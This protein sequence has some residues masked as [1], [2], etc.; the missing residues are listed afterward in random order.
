MDNALASVKGTAFGLGDAAT[1]AASAVAAGIQPG[2]DLTKYLKDVGDAAAIAGTNFEDMGSIFNKIQTSNKA[3]TD[4]L[5]Q[6]SDRGLPIFQWLQKEYGVTGEALSKMVQDGDVDSAHF[7]KAIEDN[8]SGAALKMGQSFSGSVD[9]AEAALGRLGAALLKPLFTNAAGGLGSI[10]DGLDSMTKWVNDHQAE[11]IG[12][13]TNVGVAAVSVAQDVVR[14]FG[15][16][17]QAPANS[18][19]P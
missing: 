9:N 16:M 2:Q 17:L 14:S 13:F 15:S 12:F 5:Q 1:A 7:R 4:D 11:V 3:Y 10:T 8:I 19:A 18:P 6:L